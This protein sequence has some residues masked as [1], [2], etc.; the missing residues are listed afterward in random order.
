MSQMVDS[1]VEI[2]GLPSVCRGRA[3]RAEMVLLILAGLG[4]HL[5]ATDRLF[6][7]CMSWPEVPARRKAW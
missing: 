2:V 1:P 4:L 5:Y 6:F 7:L 3:W